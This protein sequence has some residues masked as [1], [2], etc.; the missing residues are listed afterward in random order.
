[1]VDLMTTSP[2]VTIQR[3]SENDDHYTV[4]YYQIGPVIFA[5]GM[6]E[7][8]AEE[9]IKLIDSGANGATLFSFYLYD[10]FA[11][12]DEMKKGFHKFFYHLIYKNQWMN[13]NDVGIMCS[14]DKLYQLMREIIQ[15]DQRKI[16]ETEKL[17]P[18]LGQEMLEQFDPQ[19]ELRGMVT[20]L[21]SPPLFSDVRCE[22]HPS[23]NVKVAEAIT[24]GGE[25]LYSTSIRST[26]RIGLLQ[27][28]TKRFGDAG[29]FTRRED[30][31]YVQIEI[32]D[33]PEFHSLDYVPGI[34]ETL[35]GRLIR[36][37]GVGG[38]YEIRVRS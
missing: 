27:N 34:G 6:T 14:S 20:T 4:P 3:T 13:Q 10:D 26:Y 11:P 1:M 22:T 35:D 21:A 5:Y 8:A 19:A 9:F 31:G 7:K 17:W 18:S 25:F 37:V 32:W 36:Q 38:G 2:L 28:I 12:I 23:V 15:E 33:T 24:S 16:T 30:C 29:N